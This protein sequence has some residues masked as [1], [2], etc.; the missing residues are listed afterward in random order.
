MLHTHWSRA[1][2]L[3]V[4]EKIHTTPHVPLR[5]Y[6]DGFGDLCTRLV[7]PHDRIQIAADSIIE[8]SGFP[9]TAVP[10]AAECPLVAL[11][12]DSLVY[13]LSSRYCE[14]EFFMSTAWELFGG[15]AP[16]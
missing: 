7:A 15:I 8:D 12:D 9:E 6:R 2:D 16:G 13:L 3:V 4:A 10:Q 14:T 11:P 5:T 1:G